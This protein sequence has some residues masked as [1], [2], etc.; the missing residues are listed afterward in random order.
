MLKFFIPLFLITVPAAVQA[1]TADHICNPVDQERLNRTMQIGGNV[2]YDPHYWI[3]TI[4]RRA[5]TPLSLRGIMVCAGRQAQAFALEAQ[6]QT[7]QA[8]ADSLHA[9]EGSRAIMVAVGEAIKY[10]TGQP[11][12]VSKYSERR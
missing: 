2:V 6:G 8:R 7:S 4:N 11:N 1:Q 3:Q 10:V 5:E 9:A 12:R